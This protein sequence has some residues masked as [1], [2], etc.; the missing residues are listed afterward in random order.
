MCVQVLNGVAF[1]K[2]THAVVRH[3]LPSRTR[4]T[5]LLLG[6]LCTPRQAYACGMV[7]ELVALDGAPAPFSPPCAPTIP[8]GALART[9][10]PATAPG[11]V[12]A[13]APHDAVLAAAVA[14][15]TRVPADSAPA[16]AAHKRALQAGSVATMEGETYDAFIQ[17][18]FSPA[19]QA[20][21][22]AARSRLGSGRSRGSARSRL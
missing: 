22:R 12:A 15:A 14:I 4:E 5:A 20:R 2:V 11:A 18:V 9:R 7:D 10:A 1:P 3:A 8:S 17:C 6:A 21:L 16:Y 19:T 13:A